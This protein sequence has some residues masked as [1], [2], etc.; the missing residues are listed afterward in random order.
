MGK[1]NQ[2]G[3]LSSEILAPAWRQRAALARR[4]L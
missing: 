3:A 4:L 1:E 2:M